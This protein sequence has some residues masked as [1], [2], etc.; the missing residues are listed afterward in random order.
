MCYDKY[1]VGHALTAG[2]DITTWCVV[3]VCI[4][5]H[6]ILH[7]IKSL[8]LK[9]SFRGIYCTFRMKEAQLCPLAV[10]GD[11]CSKNVIHSDN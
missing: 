2:N 5:R 1:V 7:A 9:W 10:C 11:S 4:C 3:G 8:H 6:G